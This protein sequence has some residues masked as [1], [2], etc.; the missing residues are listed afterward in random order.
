[1]LGNLMWVDPR[2][3][4]CQ[5]RV[6]ALEFIPGDESTQVQPLYHSMHMRWRI[7]PVDFNV[8]LYTKESTPKI[9]KINLQDLDDALEGMWGPTTTT[10][11]TSLENNR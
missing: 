2:P 11:E 6:Q 8:L 7:W 10:T 5:N 3:E 4:E 1:M 9:T